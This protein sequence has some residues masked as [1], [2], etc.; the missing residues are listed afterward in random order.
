ME[1]AEIE[2][3]LELM[4]SVINTPKVKISKGSALMLLSELKLTNARRLP[5]MLTQLGLRDDSGNR[6][7]YADSFE[8][9]AAAMEVV[10]NFHAKSASSPATCWD[11][12]NDE[13]SYR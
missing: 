6:I 1:I 12:A 4:N 7:K 10:V 11:E 2:L 3:T 5:D 9:A 13:D 8:V